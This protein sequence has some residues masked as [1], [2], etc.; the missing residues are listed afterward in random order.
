MDNIPFY[1]PLVS[2]D[3]IIDAD[4]VVNEW[5]FRS[6][7]KLGGH[8]TIRVISYGAGLVTTVRKEL[9]VLGCGTELSNVPTLFAVDIPPSVDYALV[10][11]LLERYVAAGSLDYEESSIQHQ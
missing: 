3:D 4:L 11:S 8:S 1:A 9:A 5:V 2:V 7:M 10:I 6:V